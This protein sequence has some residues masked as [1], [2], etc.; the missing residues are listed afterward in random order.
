MEYQVHKLTKT[1]KLDGDWNKAAWKNC[2]TVE[3]KN[4]MGERPEHF[5]T[6]QAKAAYDERFIYVIF[7]VED[8]YVRAVAKKTQDMVCRDS[9]V[10]FFFTPGTDISVGYFNLEM[11]CGGTILLYHQTERGQNCRTVDC[12]SIEVFHSMPKIVEPEITE[13]T[14]W[15][16]EYKIPL[17]L[18]EKYTPVV[19][20][21][22]GVKWLGNFYKCGDA[23]SHPHWL[24]W[25]P[26]QLPKPDFHQ[27]RFFAPLEFV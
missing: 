10:E 1:I 15:I 19:K 16:V 12:D 22:P 11:N 4:F 7:R 8:R 21:A 20:P 13:P 25:N 2:P 23:T 14:T 6:V 18:L 9:C 24:T 27:P 5:P 26:V 3:I 17:A